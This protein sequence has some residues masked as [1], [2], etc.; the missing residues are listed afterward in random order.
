MA[1][2]YNYSLTTYFQTGYNQDVLQLNIYAVQD[3]KA[4]FVSIS[5]PDTDV[6]ITFS[7]ALTPAQVTELN[8]IV[9]NFNPNMQIDTFAVLAQVVPSGTGGG[10]FIAGAWVTRPLAQTG[11]QNTELWIT[12]PATNQIALVA[13]NYLMGANCSVGA[14]GVQQ[15]QFVNINVTTPVIIGTTSTGAG[16]IIQGTFTVPSG[17]GTYILQQ[18]CTVSQ[19]STGL[20]VP[21]SFPGG[22]PEVYAT[23]RI[24]RA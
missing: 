24:T 21:A 6:L 10:D 18:Q 20:G 1:T 3:L 23:M 5:A 14:V 2:T 11:G 7:Q 15:L 16:A 12:M 4:L 19:S 8:T 17:G 22:S 9:T 13:G